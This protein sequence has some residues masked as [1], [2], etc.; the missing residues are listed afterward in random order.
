MLDD[1]PDERTLPDTEAAIR[2]D[3]ALTDE[4][5]QALL[6]VYRSYVQANSAAT[7]AGAPGRQ[8]R[9]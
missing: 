3:L 2:Q 8:L 7:T 4:Q 6:G 9:T 5:K 1:E